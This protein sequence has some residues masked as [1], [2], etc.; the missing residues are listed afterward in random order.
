MY[1]VAL[2]LHCCKREGRLTDFSVRLCLDEF[3]QKI[4]VITEKNEAER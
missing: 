1:S 4:I 3:N 2:T